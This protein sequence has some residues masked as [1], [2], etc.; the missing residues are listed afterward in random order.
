M[1]LS[2]RKQPDPLSKSQAKRDMLALQEL[3]EELIQLPLPQLAKIPLPDDLL[4][5]IHF[6][7]SLK[8]N[9]ARRRHL[10]YVGK[11]MR[12]V[13][14]LPLQEA[15]AKLRLVHRKNV[16]QFHKVEECREELIEKGDEALQKLL[17]NYPDLDR[18]QLRQL[19]RKV[20]QDRANNKNTGAE[21]E[22]FK[23]LR[24]LLQ[25]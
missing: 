18:Q 2:D 22:L 14:P 16:S 3:G 8:S 5:A 20:Q 12:T 9:E 15:L 21:S 1:P 17:E 4:E 13:D 23:F 25:E 19:I 6:A 11:L 10:Q 7:H 24:E